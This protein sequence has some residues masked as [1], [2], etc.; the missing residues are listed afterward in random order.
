[1]AKSKRTNFFWVSYSDLM[2]SLFFIM[3]VLYV[4]TFSVLK[5]ELFSAQTK[6]V[7]LEKI[8]EIQQALNS[9][10]K[11]YFEFDQE[12]KRYKLKTDVKFHSSSDKITDI[13]ID[14]RI[15]ILNAG[16]DLYSKLQKMIEKN[17]KVD[18][19]LVIE[20]NTQ[21][22]YYSNI[23]NYETMPNVGYRL[24]Y[25]R[26]LAL[27]NYWKSNGVDFRKLGNQC[28]VILAGSGYFGQSRDTENEENNRR[29]TIQ[30]TSKV[31]KLIDSK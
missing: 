29:F 6:A 11:A 8:E 18:Y 26:A 31:G 23:W 27:F 3:L 1:M 20:G 17:P 13:A 28:E 16:K 4:V 2:T 21:R 7:K 22:S 24:S 19:L 5:I 9:L 25:K 14:K 15:E 12:N 10:D 30:I